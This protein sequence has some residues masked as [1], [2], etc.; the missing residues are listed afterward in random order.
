MSRAAQHGILLL[1]QQA[2]FMVLES[3]KAA[4]CEALELDYVDEP[5]SSGKRKDLLKYRF[6]IECL[7]VVGFVAKRTGTDLFLI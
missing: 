5:C 1:S 6:R 7:F 2:F 3:R 4:I